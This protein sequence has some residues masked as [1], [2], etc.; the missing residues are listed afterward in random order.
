MPSIKAKK[1]AKPK[2]KADSAKAGKAVSIWASP[3][4]R[5]MYKRVSAAAGEPLS[6]VIRVLVKGYES[7][8]LKPAGLLR[9]AE[10]PK[11]AAVA[12]AV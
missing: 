6:K 2:S 11:K 3:A 1:T 9:I 8:K 10:K 7:G 4:D 12:E 5:A